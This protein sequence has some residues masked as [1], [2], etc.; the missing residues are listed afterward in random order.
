ML[1]NYYNVGEN[2]DSMWEAKALSPTRII[3]GIDTKDLLL[4]DDYLK[5]FLINGMD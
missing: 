3:E 5:V 2:I 1:M 4:N